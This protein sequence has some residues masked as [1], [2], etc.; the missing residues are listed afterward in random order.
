MFSE[1]FAFSFVKDTAYHGLKMRQNKQTHHPA[2]LR[3]KKKKPHN[4]PNCKYAS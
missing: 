2:P 1:F 4:T 3:R